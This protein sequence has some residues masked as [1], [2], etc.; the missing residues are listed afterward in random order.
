MMAKDTP[1]AKTLEQ[2]VDPEKRAVLA[3][4]KLREEAE[5]LRDDLRAVPTDA[6]DHRLA[7]RQLPDAEFAVD[8]TTRDE[9]VARTA[10]GRAYEHH[11]KAIVDAGRP[12][13]QGASRQASRDL[14]QFQ[15]SLA[16]VDELRAEL[17]RQLAGAD[18]LVPF[19]GLAY[20]SGIADTWREN[21]RADHLL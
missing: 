7:Q 21:L 17:V 19:V 8:I 11:R 3:A 12:L 6:A 9:Q 18:N 14:D 13:L 5:H 15:R 16:H 2:L 20:L 1:T 4:A 10:L